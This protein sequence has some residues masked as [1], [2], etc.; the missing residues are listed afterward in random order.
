L[1]VQSFT[2]ESKKSSAVNIHI[3]GLKVDVSEEKDV[4]EPVSIQ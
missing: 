2:A 4:S 1:P 3:S